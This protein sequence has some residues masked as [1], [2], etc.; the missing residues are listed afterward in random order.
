MA[1]IDTAKAKLDRFMRDEEGERLQP[2]LCQAG[3]PTIGVGATSYLDGRK[4]TLADPPISK[5]QMDR[6]LSVELDRYIGAVVGMTDGQ[7]GTNQLIAFVLCSYNIGIEGLRGSSMMKAHCRGDYAAAARAFTL[8][9]KYRPKPGAKLEESK[10]LTA[11]RLRESA[12]YLT[13]D[14]GSAGVPQAVQAESSLAKSP[15][16]QVGAGG[17]VSGGATVLA[18]F[19]GQAQE[20]SGSVSLIAS[21]A[22][23][24][25]AAVNDI[26][27]AVSLTPGEL[28]GG[29]LLIGGAV[30]C[31]QRWK[32]RTGGWA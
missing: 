21:V 31:Y 29:L 14:D 5:E 2:Y 27:A 13:A 28:L 17:I 4:V 16:A 30:V 12:I 7:I 25:R 23:A 3:R 8:W 11:R 1:N 20:V 22:T 32:Q 24:V 26:A 18:T 19:G 9:N 10:G 6:M 15:M